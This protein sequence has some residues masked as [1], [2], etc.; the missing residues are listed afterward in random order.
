MIDCVPFFVFV[1]L[2]A[3]VGIVVDGNEDNTSK[4]E[5]KRNKRGRVGDA[6]LYSRF[7]SAE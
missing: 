2:D 1:L 4:V 3:V 6:I 7:S 5:E